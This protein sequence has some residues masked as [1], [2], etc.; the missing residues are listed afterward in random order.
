MK[1]PCAAAT[2]RDV[3]NQRDDQWLMV[4]SVSARMMVAQILLMMLR[5]GGV[6][7]NTVMHTGAEGHAAVPMS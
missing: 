1:C 4:V 5:G 3:T 7:G 6:L 2:A